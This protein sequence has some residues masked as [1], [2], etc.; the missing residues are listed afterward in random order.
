[1]KRSVLGLLAVGVL[2][3]I[4]VGRLVGSHNRL[5]DELAGTENRLAVARNRYNEQVGAFNAMVQRFP[6]NIFANMLGFKQEPFYPVSA[7]AKQT[8]KVD[9]G[10]LRNTPAP[11]TATTPPTPNKP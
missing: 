11:G 8:P 7:E 5:V 2:L 1:M 9:F 3:L 4:V 10:G 6:T